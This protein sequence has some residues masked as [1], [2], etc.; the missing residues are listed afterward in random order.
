MKASIGI[1]MLA[2]LMIGTS[3]QVTQRE[4]EHFFNGKDLEGW[5]ATQ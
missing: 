4:E 2:A 5:K 3:E 1:G